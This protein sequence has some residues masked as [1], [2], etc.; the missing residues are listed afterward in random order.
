MFPTADKRQDHVLRVAYIDPDVEEIF[1]EPEDGEDH[2][3]GL[4]PA[5]K[6]DKND[7]GYNELRER[8][9]PDAQC[10]PEEAEE[11]MTEFVERQVDII[12]QKKPVAVKQRV[13]PE[14]DSSGDASESDRTGDG[15]MGIRYMDLR[16]ISSSFKAVTS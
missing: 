15:F 7:K 12:E 10:I 14:E 9:A 11:Y 2:P 3:Q 8:P 1:A 5:G 6:A 4:A 16:V 13:Y